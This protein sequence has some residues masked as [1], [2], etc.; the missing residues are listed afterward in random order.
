MKKKSKK[1][2]ISLRMAPD[3][4]IKIIIVLGVIFIW[5]GMWNIMDKFF[6]P[7][8]FLFSNIFGIIIGLILIYLPDSDLD[9]LG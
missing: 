6:L 8:N 5:R 3:F 7:D 4:L 9:E 2:G 1:L